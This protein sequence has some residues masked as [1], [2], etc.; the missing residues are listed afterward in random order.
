MHS[1]LTLTAKDLRL[2]A[3]DK[4][5]LFWVLGFPLI[6]GLFFG[7]IA[8][9]GAGEQGKISIA[10]VDEDDSPS[11]QALIK[12]LSEHGSLEVKSADSLHIDRLDKD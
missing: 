4:M 9:G 12:K 7:V 2:L 6:F 8:G 3:R 1:M 5:A 10:F 11:S